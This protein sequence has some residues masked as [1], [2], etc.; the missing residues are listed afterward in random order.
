MKGKK[1]LRFTAIKNKVLYIVVGVAFL[2]YLLF[3]LIRSFSQSLF[4][5]SKDRINIIVYGQ[6]V[7]YYSLA[8]QESRD[9]VVYFPP[10]MKVQVPGGYE[11]YRVGSIGK[12]IKL[13]NNPDLYRKTFSL[14]TSSFVN[15]Y[16]YPDTVD[17]YY[18]EGTKENYAKLTLQDFF[19]MK[20]NA[21][22]LDRV[23]LAGFVL[24]K[25]L[26]KF[27]VLRYIETEKIRDDIFFEAE[28]FTKKSIGLF[29]QKTY[30]NEQKNIQIA[31]NNN[32]STAES[33]GKMLEGNGIRIS[34][35]TLNLQP[36]KH[37]IVRESSSIHSATAHH[38]AQ[39]L[40]CQLITGKTD[41]YDII[42]ELGDTEKVWEVN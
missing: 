5:N 11:S 29:F 8:I 38:I 33:I 42:L 6:N 26:S 40:D 23:Y 37:C 19:F 10:E 31:Y 24:N 39:F 34:D 7:A 35:I 4:F 2:L 12:L 32:Y 1:N 41:V 17:V 15:Y 14:A 36:K 25:D 28:E 18:G 16:F 30:R 3:I 9:Y 22:F 21:S 13:D 20:S 27:R